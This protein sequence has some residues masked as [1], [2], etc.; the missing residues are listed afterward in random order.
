MKLAV[1]ANVVGAPRTIPKRIDKETGRLG[2]KR[3]RRDHPRSVRILNREKPLA[4]VGVKNLQRSKM[5]I[6]NTPTHSK[7]I[8]PG[9]RNG[10]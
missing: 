6:M 7:N 10:I 9:Y 8:Q 2:N 5:I 3:T 1:I 4:N